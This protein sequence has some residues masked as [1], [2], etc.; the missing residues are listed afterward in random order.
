MAPM[1]LGSLTAELSP[2]DLRQ[3]LMTE[4]GSVFW[5]GTQRE[6]LVRQSSKYFL[7]SAFLQA[8]VWL[9]SNFQAEALWT[10]GAFTRQNKVSGNQFLDITGL[11]PFKT[12]FHRKDTYSQV[13]YN[14]KKKI[15]WQNS[16]K[17]TPT[18]FLFLQN[19]ASTKLTENQTFT[20]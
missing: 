1:F 16:K 20:Y 2:P 13:K 4:T 9:S 7:I 3:V 17:P 8:R 12:L 6:A 10:T 11:R 14:K 19:N 18:L 5:L 15:N